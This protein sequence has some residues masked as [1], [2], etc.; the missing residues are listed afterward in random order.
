M[1]RFIAAAA[2]LTIASTAS[3]GLSYKVQSSTTGLQNITIIGTVTVE[4]SRLRMDVARGDNTLFKDNGIV[5]SN[6]GGR[7][8]AVL[9]PATMNYFDL[10]L[11]QLL[12]TGTS[13]LNSLGGMV[14]V[15]FNNPHV[16]VRDGGS[17]G[18][19]EGYPSHKYVLEASYDMA[20]DAMG[21][22]IT[23]HFTM[24]TE[25]WTTEQL[26]ADFSSFIQARSMRTGVEALDKLI[27]AQRGG[28][29]GFPLKQVSTVHVSQG[30]SE[31]SMVS[32]SS[33]TDIERRAIE[34]S[35]FVMPA[36]YTKVDDPI[37]RMMKQLKQQ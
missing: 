13:M 12:A 6:D 7:T 36:G 17:G 32:T 10:Q 37:T 18:T 27:E 33:V 5:L 4:G 3:A 34:P 15:S 25:S 24:N 9:D 28:M 31:M 14:K 2:L 11:D 35:Q 19:I 23:S 30:G 21:Q 16:E 8:M 20:I 26:S 1:K 22:K 29:H